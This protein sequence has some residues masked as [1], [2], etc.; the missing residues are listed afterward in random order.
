MKKDKYLSVSIPTGTAFRLAHE[1]IRDKKSRIYINVFKNE[2]K[3]ESKHPDYINKK[4]D[5]LLYENTKK[6][7]IVEEKIPEEKVSDE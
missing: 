6:D 5:A 2:K 1:A 3:T 4:I 7:K